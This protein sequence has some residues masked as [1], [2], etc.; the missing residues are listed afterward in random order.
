MSTRH[1]A[2]VEEDPD[3]SWK[4]G[5]GS[6]IGD[7]GLLTSSDSC[8]IRRA[9]HFAIGLTRKNAV[10]RAT[11]TATTDVA[12]SRDLETEMATLCVPESLRM[13]N[14]PSI[15]YVAA[16]ALHVAAAVA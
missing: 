11:G 1:V 14:F 12:A 16:S 15:L 10:G 7:H 6:R 13:V 2:L 4:E 9:R 5:I 3:T 8:S